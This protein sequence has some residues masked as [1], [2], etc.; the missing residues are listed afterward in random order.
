MTTM[1]LNVWFRSFSLSG[2]LLCQAFGFSLGFVMSEFIYWVSVTWI[3]HFGFCIS[4][5]WQKVFLHP[6]FFSLERRQRAF[7]G[8]KHKEI[9]TKTQLN[10]E[11]VNHQQKESSALSLASDFC[12]F[13]WNL[14][15]FIKKKQFI[16]C[17]DF[18]QM[19][20]NKHLGQLVWG[21]SC[22]LSKSRTLETIR[23]LFVW[24]RLWWRWS[25]KQSNDPKDRIHS[26]LNEELLKVCLDLHDPLAKTKPE[27][28]GAN[29]GAAEGGI[30]RTWSLF[31]DGTGEIL[32]RKETVF[33][34]GKAAKGDIAMCLSCSLCFCK[35][36]DEFLCVSWTEN[37]DLSFI[38]EP[39]REKAKLTWELKRFL[40]R[41][42]TNDLHSKINVRWFMEEKIRMTMVKPQFVTLFLNIKK[43]PVEGCD[44]SPCRGKP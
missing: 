10:T 26:R 41:C 12:K 40:L 30:P 2:H 42:S 15:F 38:H 29:R 7:M 37:W 13:L 39:V 4:S 32:L 44:W 5:S 20:S 22:C 31:V 9:A 19:G 14:S 17:A 33:I 1:Y 3:L 28:C 11:Q 8:R 36:S 27:V 34:F 43:N 35:S 23:S 6:C 25:E 21:L 16:P 24:E 18:L